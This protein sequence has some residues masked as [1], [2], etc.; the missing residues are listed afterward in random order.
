M[1]ISR[2][3][4]VGLGIAAVA[5]TVLLTA[6]LAGAQSK[7]GAASYPRNQTM[8]TTGTMWS[9]YQDLNPFK[10][11]DYATGTVGLAYETLFQYSPFTDSYVP[12]LATKATWNKASTQLT[13]LVRKGVKFSDGVALTG[14][15]VKFTFE[16]GK[17]EATSTLHPLWTTGGL[18][19]ISAKGNTV[20]FNFKKGAV[21]QEFALSL[22]Q[23]AIVPKHVFSGYSGTDIA[24]GNLADTS[25]LIGTGPYVYADGLNS[26][27]AFVWQKRSGWW[28]TKA[29]KLTVKPTY[30]IDNTNYSNA[31]ALGELLAGNVD[32][33]NNFVPGIDQKVGSTIATYFKKAPYML[34][35]NT[36]W[37]VPNT[38]RAPTSDPKFRL[39]LAQSININQIVSADY[40]NIVKKASPTG[41]LQ[42]WKKYIDNKAVKKYGFSYS[43]SKAKA[44]LAAA[45]YKDANGDGFVENKDGSKINLEIICPN[46][47]S[48]WMTA[49]QIIAKSSA[50][51]GIKIT[52]AYPDYSALVDKRGPGNYDLLLSNDK[53]LGVTPWDYYN[54]MFQLPILANQ[55]TVNFE[56]YNNATAWALVQ[57][58][59][60][61]P[62]SNLKQMKSIISKLSIIQMQNLPL[63]P[64]WYNGVWAQ[65][66]TTHWTSW[67]SSTQ[68]QKALPC[69]WRGYL[70][71]TGIFML[72]SLKAA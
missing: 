15:D 72:T 26:N 43:I 49:I 58:L 22:Y 60:R 39:A 54:F 53:Q 40:G 34:S 55:T 12:W 62:M 2:K 63:I 3:T 35:A 65:S 14:A 64:L 11:W 66:N 45:G 29:L 20:K 41:L 13:V 71:M 68:K 67:P 51:A 10:T 70:N 23:Q 30:I 61:T 38:S 36:A 69:M 32:L 9:P 50:G 5:A 57:K 7:S 21:Y 8:Y 48:D 18:K 31:A 28:A 44:T 1:K 16:T 19:S 59:D 42:Y 24:S 6:S 37:L 47:W 56:R 25:K 27:E 46:G 52:P 33:S 17:T 4:V